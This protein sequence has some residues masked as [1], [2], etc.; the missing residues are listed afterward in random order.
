MSGQADSPEVESLL[1]DVLRPVEPPET[2]GMR[3][4]S[5]LTRITEAAAD[6]LADWEIEAMHDP[7]N[8]VR[9]V[10]AVATGGA[11]ATGLVLIEMRRRRRP[12]RLGRV[13]SELD[14]LAADAQRLLRR[15]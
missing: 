8:W 12:H 4:E 13:R 15:G 11:A 5:A 9:P 1:S 3:V 10:V 14:S 7:R 6:E 2:L